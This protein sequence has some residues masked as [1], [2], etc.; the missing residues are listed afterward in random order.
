MWD[1]ATGRALNQSTDWY[2]ISGIGA[3]AFS[4]DGRGIASAGSDRI[5]YW[6]ADT[7][8]ATGEAIQDDSAGIAVA[9]SPDGRS[10]VTGG[11]WHA[12]ALGSTCL[13]LD[14]RWPTDRVLQP[15]G[16]RS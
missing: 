6:D 3:L 14:S 4:P 12:P 15:R 2:P 11:G 1:G 7:L 10:I 13:R 5:V 16:P 9:F 8:K